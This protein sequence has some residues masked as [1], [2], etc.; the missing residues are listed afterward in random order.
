MQ[1]SMSMV[2]LLLLMMVGGY[3]MD[4]KILA[5]IPARGGSKGIPNKNIRLMNGKPLIVHTIDFLKKISIPIDIVVSTDSENIANVAKQSCVDVVMRPDFLAKD[6]SLVID[7]IR[8]TIDFLKKNNKEYNYIF[9]FEPTSPLRRKIDI[10]SC[11]NILISGKYDSIVSFS[12]TSFSVGRLFNIDNNKITPILQGNNYL[13]GRQHQPI[14]YRCDGIIY[15]FTL[16]ILDKYKETKEIFMGKVYPYIIPYVNDDIDNIYEFYCVE[17][18]L[19]LGYP[20]KLLD[21]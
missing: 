4:S 21:I 17:Y 5:I 2:K 13:L 20:E 3:N 7:A 11:I 9:L 12:E 18:L 15:G 19:S 10:E 6:D 1:A 8:Y 16:D 14:S